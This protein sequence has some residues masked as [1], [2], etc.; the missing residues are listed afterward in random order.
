M[1]IYSGFSIRIEEKCSLCDGLQ[2]TSTSRCLF[3][4]NMMKLDR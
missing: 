3:D 2:H 1:K 4:L